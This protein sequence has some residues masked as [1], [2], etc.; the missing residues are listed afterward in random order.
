MLLVVAFSSSLD[1]AAIE[2]E[3]GE[4]AWRGRERGRG[5]LPCGSPHTPLTPRTPFFYNFSPRLAPGLR[6]RAADGRL[7]QLCERLLRRLH[8][9]VY[10]QSD[11]FY[12]PT[13]RHRR[14]PCVWLVRL[15][16]SCLRWLLL[17]TAAHAW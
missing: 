7:V 10:L 3:L 1:V 8:R 6:P 15:C 11:D 17:Y 13:G 12:P 5:R 16:F 9:L 2:M 14:L 4:R